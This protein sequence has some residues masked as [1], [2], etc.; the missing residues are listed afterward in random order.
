[1]RSIR[2]SIAGLMGIVL[3]AAVG[4]AALRNASP[5]W[6]GAMGLLTCGILAL[7]VVGLLCRGRTERPWW[8]GVCLFGWG[9]L[10][11]SS[12]WS[13]TLASML[14]TTRL[15]EILE[16]WLGPSRPVHGANG[17]GGFGAGGGGGYGGDASL[18]SPYVQAGHCLWALLAALLGG[19]LARLVFASREARPEESR[20]AGEET[21]WRPRSRRLPAAIA[22]MVA[23]ILVGAVATIRWRS[24]SAPWA[25]ITFAL[26]CA[27]IG[28]AIVG[29]VLGRGRRREVWLGAAL[30]GAGYA[31]LIFSRPVGQPP[32]A[33]LGTDRILGALRPWFPPVAKS[34]SGESARILE[35]LDQPIPMQFTMETPLDDVLKYI[36]QATTTP[37]YPGIPIYVDPLGLQE[38]ERSLNSTVQINL[39]R[40]PLHETLRLCLKQ[41][42]LGFGIKDGYL[43]ITAEDWAS[44][45]LEDPFL[46]VGHCLLALL[47]AGFGAVAAPIVAERCREPAGLRSGSVSDSHPAGSTPE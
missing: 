43:W 11:L 46:I 27:V 16:P 31:A 35:I 8:L 42:D 30:F 19:L 3:V 34:L 7:A 12:H 28:L 14:P 24:H 41:L 25:G 13:E 36:Q 37:T 23:L 21:G 5:T 45:D 26:T 4:L 29:A 15:L 22:G 9:Y 1:M 10:V 47:A 32:R 39:D 20:P 44:S 18:S 40:V 38:A 6:A 2:F 17:G 33:Y